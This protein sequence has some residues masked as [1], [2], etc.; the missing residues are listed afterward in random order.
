MGSLFLGLLLCIAINETLVC[1][2]LTMPLGAVGKL[3]AQ[4]LIGW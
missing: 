3:F 1:L 2:K 4:K